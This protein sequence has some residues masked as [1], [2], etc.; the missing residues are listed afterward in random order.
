MGE[1]D[2]AIARSAQGAPYT[3]DNKPDAL[4][5]ISGGGVLLGRPDNHPSNPTADDRY[6]YD[7]EYTEADEA[8]V[9]ELTGGEPTDNATAQRR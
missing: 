2:Q 6:Y 7:H 8:E 3:A 1:T 4:A 9:F 5:A